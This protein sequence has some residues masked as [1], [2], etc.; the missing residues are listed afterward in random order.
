VAAAAAAGA[1]AATQAQPAPP[2]PNSRMHPEKLLQSGI[3]GEDQVPIAG[4][5]YQTPNPAFVPT[6]PAAGN[7]QTFWRSR[8]FKTLISGID[9][10]D[11]DGDGNQEIVFAT[12][13]LV[14][15]YQLQNGRLIKEAET[16]QTRTGSY[17]GVDI[18]DVNGNGIPEIYVTGLASNRSRVQSLVLEYNGTDYQTISQGNSWYYRVAQTPDRGTVLLGQRHKAA[19]DSIYRGTIHEMRWEGDDIVAGTELLRGGK[20]NLMGVAYGDVTQSGQ[21]SIVA[22]SKED[23]MR[24][25]DSDKQMIVEDDDRTGGNMAFFNL[26][27]V[28]PG[29]PNKQ[30]FPL[31]IRT[32]DIDRDGKTEIMVALHKEL[33]RSLM[34]DF[35][36]FK[37][38]RIEL[39]EWNGLTFASKWKTQEFKGRV[40]DFVVGDFDNDGMDELL[41]SVVAK[42]GSIALM[43]AVSRIIAF[44][45]N[46]S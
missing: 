3:Q 23:R 41:V 33:A 15:V 43:N 31:R 6:A 1:V 9:V 7:Q 32:V 42:E 16:A 12:E 13:D 46:V 10:A 37:N 35:R 20:T 40:S 44:D 8:S 2:V 4:Q 5:P 17:I 34:K 28:E 26:P 11:V 25:Y 24:I 39:K 21:S 14:A 18:G 27:K 29:D 38:G 30:F 22:Y 36:S 45:L 19:A